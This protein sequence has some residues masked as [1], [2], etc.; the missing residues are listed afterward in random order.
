MSID[1]ENDEVL[2]SLKDRR[3]I[4]Q[5]NLNHLE[6]QRAR[7]GSNPPISLINDID[8]E[9]LAIQDLD[10]RIQERQEYLRT[11]ETSRP[12]KPDGD[13]SKVYNS[14]STIRSGS[15]EKPSSSR[16]PLYWAFVGGGLVFCMLMTLGVG[17]LLGLQLFRETSTPTPLSISFISETLTSTPTS[18]PTTESS[19]TP[20]ATLTPPPSPEPEDFVPPTGTAV[21]VLAATPT[22]P[23]P[24]TNSPPPSFTPIGVEVAAITPTPMLPPTNTPIPPEPT[25]IP[26]TTPTF[27]L[28]PLPPPTT[29]PTNIPP[30]A[31]SIPPPVPS[32]NYKVTQY[33]R[34][35]PKSELATVYNQSNKTE[36]LLTGIT[37]NFFLYNEETPINETP[38]HVSLLFWIP[39]GSLNLAHGTLGNV[40]TVVPMV[41]DPNDPNNTSIYHS[42]GFHKGADGY[43]D[44]VFI[45]SQN[46]Y[47]LVLLRGYVNY[48]QLDTII[49]KIQ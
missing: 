6:E 35:Y 15:Q 2:T 16:S 9:T 48:P 7:Y 10:E 14:P 22:Q 29:I 41:Y 26:T 30:P 33:L 44:V 11:A 20:T 47:T 21:A 43:S 38:L 28:T 36:D 4:H 46:L 31:C 24:P 13:A 3:R 23:L 32:A 39:T 12:V 45:C 1:S 40:Y 34:V 8:H 5:K 18:S 25:P 37:E 27:T 19:P 42:G 17:V 49:Q